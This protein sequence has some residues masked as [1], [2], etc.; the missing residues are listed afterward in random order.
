MAA[1]TTRLSRAPLLKT[2]CIL[3]YSRSAPHKPNRCNLW[4]ATFASSNSAHPFGNLPG[5]RIAASVAKNGKQAQAAQAY[6]GPR[7]PRLAAMAW[8]RLTV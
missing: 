7:L 4:D 2:Q 5:D 3:Q 6:L 1:K 8:T